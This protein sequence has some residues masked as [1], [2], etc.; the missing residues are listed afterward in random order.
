MEQNAIWLVALI[1]L[2]LSLAAL[3][4]IRQQLEAHRLLDFEW[5][6]HNRTRALNHGID[7]GLSAIESVRDFF[8]ASSEVDANSFQTFAES[9]LKRVQGVHAL[10]WVPRRP[11]SEREESPGKGDA[12]MALS[13]G[14]LRRAYG[15]HTFPVTYSSPTGIAGFSKGTDLGAIPGFL[16]LL[17]QAGDSGLLAASGRIDFSSQGQD[18][19]SGYGIMAALPVYDRD[20]PNDMVSRRRHLAGFVVGLFRLSDLVRTSI[21]LLEPRGVEILVLDESAPPDRQF[22]HF[23]ASRLVPR[24]I[25]VS[26]YGPWLREEAEAKLTERIKVA[27]RYWSIIS[28][29][30]DHFRSAEAFQQGPWV[31][32]VAGLLFTLLLSFYL[33]RIRENARQRREMERQLV[34]REALFRQMME[35]VDE[36]FWA[37]SADGRRLLYLSPAYEKITGNLRTGLDS[38]L[39]DAVHPEDPQELGD[40]LSRVCREKSD[41]EVIHPIQRADGTRRWI[42]TRGFPVVDEQGEVIRL[43]GFSE[44]I[45]ERKIA[46]EALRESEAQLRDLFQQSP[47][48]IMTVDKRG[49]ILLM[50]RSIP[51][52]PAERAVGRNSLALMPSDFRNWY[53]RALAAVFEENVTRQFEYSTGDGVYWAGRV[54]P[55]HTEGAVTAAMVIASDVTEKRKL[56]AQSLRNARLASIGV[57]AA[58]VAHEINNPNNAIQFNA[59]LISRVWAD[60]QPILSEYS[61]ENGDFAVGGLAYSEAAQSLPQLLSD[62]GGNSERIRRIVLNLKHMARQDQG[63]YAQ[64][65]DIGQMLETAMLILHNQ[66]QKYTDVC[67]LDVAPGLPPVRGNSQQLE[68]VFINLLLNA[69]QSLPERS[70]GVHI[71]AHYQADHQRVDIRVKDEGKGVSEHDM[72]RLTEPFFT[73]RTESGGTGLGLSIARSIMEKH[74]GSLMFESKPG[75]GTV[76]TMRLPCTEPASEIWQ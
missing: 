51:E 24:E 19:D 49:T 26:N 50:N 41:I 42:R 21:S 59:S 52:L 7:N 46:D 35:T 11:G 17:E 64:R 22:L 71:T 73:T 58:G 20:L 47:D 37:A 1:G 61:R 12:G 31:V 45:T 5:V 70:R 6:A 62:I 72:G 28:G 68:Q 32:L 9:L 29:R 39:V 40:A 55:L 14:E 8:L 25:G 57:L 67:V 56:E 75:E 13:R 33:E 30:T 2:T 63:D 53:K 27:D 44:D 43:V 4:L 66:V 48:I 65:V 23:Y 74:G 69:L 18:E 76:V 10:M 3:W 38:S 60:I 36:A 34:E 54:Q 16:K 15:S